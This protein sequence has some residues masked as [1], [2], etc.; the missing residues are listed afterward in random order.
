MKHYT[1]LL[2]LTFLPLFALAQDKEA[3]VNQ[4]LAAYNQKDYAGSALLY[5]QSIDKGAMYSDNYYNA[6]CSYALAGD[7]ENAFLF[8]EQSIKLGYTNVSH[9]QKDSDFDSLHTDNR[10]PQMVELAGVMA[11]RARDFWDSPAMRTPY[12]PDLSVEE[13]VA[14]VSKLWSEVKYNF[15]NFDLVPQLNWDSLYMACLPKVI[16][17][18]NT[19]DYYNL[20]TGMIAQLHD[21]HSNVNPP[22]TLRDSVW[23]IP[24]FRTR[25]IENKVLVAVVYDNRLREQG[26]KEGVELLEI[27]GLPVKQYAEKYVRPY[28]SASTPQDLDVRTYE[29]SL[30]TG[31]AGSTVKL[32]FADDKGGSFVR[33]ITRITFEQRVKYR[34]GIPGYQRTW[35][36]DS[37]A[38]ISLNNFEDDNV[39]NS[40]IKDFDTLRRARAIIFDIRNNGGGS[41]QVG[42]AILACLT[43]KPFPGSNWRTREYHPAYRAWGNPDGWTGGGNNTWN[44]N[45][46]LCYDGPVY[47]LAGPKTFSAAEDFLVGFDAMHRGTIVGEPSGGSTGQPLLFLLPGG[48]SARVCAKRDSYPDGKDFVGIGIQPNILVHPT[49]ADFKKGRDN[50]LE[51]TLAVIRKK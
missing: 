29:Y 14:G 3:L 13:K 17:T 10:W 4:A 43:R 38:L 21:G 45:G 36:K 15:A 33:A 41:T 18:K 47:V 23:A 5:K 12:K 42:Y 40:F 48:G 34:Y 46:K 22:D 16:A 2:I 37:I 51:A 50:A 39:A 31:A 8:L 6:A 30:L 32:R 28:Q 1:R 7:K 44:P 11:K 20:L 27:D 49:A 35:L 24:A 26:I 25:L 19:V 9:L